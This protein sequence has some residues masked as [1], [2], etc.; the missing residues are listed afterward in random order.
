MLAGYTRTDLEVAMMFKANTAIEHRSPDE[1]IMVKTVCLEHWGAPPSA[2]DSGRYQIAPLSARTTDL[3]MAIARLYQHPDYQQLSEDERQEVLQD[4]VWLVNDRWQGW[5]RSI[6]RDIIADAVKGTAVAAE[7]DRR[8]VLCIGPETFANCSALE[9]YPFL[10]DLFRTRNHLDPGEMIITVSKTGVVGVAHAQDDQRILSIIDISGNN[11]ALRA[12]Y[13][14]LAETAKALADLTERP[15]DEPASD[16]QLDTSVPGGP[17]Q[18]SHLGEGAPSAEGDLAEALA[19][20]DQTIARLQSLEEMM[21]SLTDQSE[22]IERARQELAEAYQAYTQEA[23]PTLAELVQRHQSQ[24]RHIMDGSQQIPEPTLRGCAALLRHHQGK[25]DQLPSDSAA[26]DLLAPARLL[27]QIHRSVGALPRAILVKVSADLGPLHLQELYGC[28]QMA[29]VDGFDQP[30]LLLELQAQEPEPLRT[31]LAQNQPSGD[32]PSREL[33]VPT[34]GSG[35]LASLVADLERAE[36]TAEAASAAFQLARLGPDGI[37]ALINRVDHEQGQV[38]GAAMVVLARSGDASVLQIVQALASSSLERTSSLAIVL[39]RIGEPAMQPLR[40]ALSSAD[41]NQRAGAT[42]ALSV[43]DE[44]DVSV[45]W[46][47]IDDSTILRLIDDLSNPEPNVQAG[48]PMFLSALGPRAVP[49]LILRL[50]MANE[51]DA[52]RLAVV[53]GRCGAPAVD[54]L[55][56]LLEEGPGEAATRALVA[57]GRIGEPAIAPLMRCLENT[58]E[59]A[60]GEVTVALHQIGQPALDPL[61]ECLKTT[62]K[63]NTPRVAA[64][65]ALFGEPAIDPLIELL[66]STNYDV[67]YRAAIALIAIG[68]AAIQPLELLL[69]TAD[70]WEREMAAIALESIRKSDH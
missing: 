56:R 35:S 24:A 22:S 31:A 12:R 1:P 7:L 37:E 43:L 6:H 70:G 10:H 49:L 11:S 67:A 36:T 20:L 39:S 47:L 54:P 4:L 9:G 51:A 19:A 17:A 45:D 48:V 66:G 62:E 13:L 58:D 55:I 41:V 33:G 38:S 25:F 57:L 14:K 27:V 65:L 46:D 18:D 29:G 59:I 30:V 26:S 5:R 32:L 50:E 64:A 21:Q 53:L 16:Q 68:E 15:D 63:Q 23:A 3:S 61:F 40:S 44:Y 60:A 2:R 34:A 42:V 28:L 52:A 69:L 8:Y